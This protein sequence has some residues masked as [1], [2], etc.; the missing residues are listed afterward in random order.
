MGIHI[1]FREQ[2]HGLQEVESRKDKLIE[3]RD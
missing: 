2:F 3:V 1:S